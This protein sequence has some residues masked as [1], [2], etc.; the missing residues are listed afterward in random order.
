MILDV[1]SVFDTNTFYRL[2]VLGVT[3]WFVGL[4]CFV[5]L[6]RRVVWVKRSNDYVFSK[7]LLRFT[8]A[9]VEGCQGSQFLGFYLI[10]PCLFISL[11][12][13]NLTNTI[14]YFFPFICHVPFCIIFAFFLWS[15]LVLSRILNRWEQVVGSLVPLNSPIVL[16]P[17]LVI[18]EVVSSLIRP[19]ALTVRLVFNLTSGQVILGL[20]AQYNNNS[21]LLFGVTV[22]NFVNV[23]VIVVS[24]LAFGGFFLFEVGVAVLQR[25][26][27]CFLL[28]RYSDDHSYWRDVKLKLAK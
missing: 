15:I 19:I 28:C 3:V 23:L 16:A 6:I 4:G 11:L 25:Y 18:V 1:F 8:I 2:G 20:I 14:P 5:V 13:I 24:L 22:I 17:L 7:R 12:W 21:V 27:F 10:I 9:I 26:I